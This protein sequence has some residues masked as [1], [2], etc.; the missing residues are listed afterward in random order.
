MSTRFTRTFGVAQPIVQAGMSWASSNPALPAAVSNAGGLGV[1]AAGPMFIEDFRKALRT[2]K[3]ATDKPFA[4]NVPLYR[5]QADEILDI[6][7]EEEAPILIA[8]QGGPKKYLSRFQTAGIKC[9]HV[10]ASEAHALKAL[11]AGVDAIVAVG[12]E[13]GGHPPPDQVST[14][15]LVRAIAKAAPE[16]V[17]IAGG[18]VAD[19]AG[20][21]AMLALGAD[22][23]QLGTRYLATK[24]ASVHEAYKQK[25]LAAG[26]A[27][28]ALVGSGM[29]P[30]RMVRNDF[31]ARFLEAEAAGA[32]IEARRAMFA[33]SSLKL[34]ALDGDVTNGKIEA[35][36]SAGLI[37]D[38]PGAEELTLRLIAEYR[39][40]L[41]RLT[42]LDIA[43]ES[44]LE[45][46]LQGVL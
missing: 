9:I 39:S 45:R 14:L 25:V 28:T 13:A 7:I 21:V 8:S 22:A 1:L 38:L 6:L 23:V 35:G 32:G 37:D 41:A 11:E 40:A 2:L 19:G 44:R 4:V 20:I 12:G 3:A 30:I 27:D 33:T 5:P 18:G 17:L 36:Q 10:V 26:I 42:G 43:L 31:S 46:R 29:S 34:A 24:E 15:V 16:A